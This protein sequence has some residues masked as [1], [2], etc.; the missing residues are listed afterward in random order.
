MGVRILIGC[1]KLAD[2][3]GTRLFGWL[4]GRVDR[5]L[6]ATSWLSGESHWT[7]ARAEETICQLEQALFRG[8]MRH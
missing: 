2:V 4:S 6:V 5:T 7:E 3:C 8:R 1:Q